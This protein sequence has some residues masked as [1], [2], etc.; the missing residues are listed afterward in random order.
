[1]SFASVPQTHEQYPL[2]PDLPSGAIE[3]SGKTK[4]PPQIISKTCGRLQ[5]PLTYVAS[6]TDL[7]GTRLTGR[8]GIEEVRS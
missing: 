3:Y 2:Y 4:Q 6:F 1:L 5:C 8:P 7:W